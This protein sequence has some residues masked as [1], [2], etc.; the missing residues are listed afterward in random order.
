MQRFTDQTLGSSPHIA[1]LSSSKVGNFVVLTPLLRGLKEKYPGCTLDFFGS[2]T[3]TDFETHC[4]YVD[5]R[6]SLYSPRDDY[7][8][9]LAA[10]V[11]TRTRKAGGYDLAINCDEFS[12][13][14]VVVA[15]TLRPRYLAG[16]ALDKD[17][18]S[19][20]PRGDDP[21]ER[22]LADDDWNATATY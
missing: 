16:A 1:V 20:P 2:D 3:T 6:F 11:D 9:A 21:V 14:N 8:G 13:L 12:E 10:F 7:L 5:A 17:F 4:D 15:S 18:R 22:M 19:R